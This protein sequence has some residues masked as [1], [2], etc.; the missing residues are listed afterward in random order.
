M[1]ELRGRAALAQLS[2]DVAAGLLDPYAAAD[3]L[4]EG[5]TG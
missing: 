4:I 1:D 5:V 2:A 3:R